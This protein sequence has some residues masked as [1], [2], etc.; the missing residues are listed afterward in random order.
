VLGLGFIFL[1][2]ILMFDPS[3]IAIGNILFICG[4]FATIGLTRSFNL[5]KRFFYFPKYYDIIINFSTA[6]F[7]LFIEI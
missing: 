5:F 1:G 3:M 2:V 4:L 6:E 7:F